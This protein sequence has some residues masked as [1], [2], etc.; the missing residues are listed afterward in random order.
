[1]KIDK[2]KTFRWMDI[3]YYIIFIPIFLLLIPTD[4]IVEKDPYFFTILMLYM[5]VIHFI[6]RKYNPV[7]YMIEGE[8]LK[9]SASAGATLAI[10]IILS[11]VEAL[12]LRH[13][14]ILSLNPERTAEM[15]IRSIWLLYFIEFTFITTT[16]LIMEIVRQTE[17]RARIEE[18]KNRAELSLYKSQINPHFM[19]N[20]LNTL[21]G[22]YITKSDKTGDMFLKFTDMIKYTFSTNDTNTVMLDKEVEYITEYIDLQSLRLGS[23]TTV[24]FECNIDDPSVMIPPMILITFVENAFKYG[25]SSSQKNEIKISISLTNRN[26]HFSTENTIFSRCE[27]SSTGIGIANCRKRLELLYPN[28]YTLFSGEEQG[29]NKYFTTLNIKL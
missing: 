18:Q 15:K 25:V 9:L 4:I 19:L 13:F 24:T 14:N 1:M 8:W 20:T 10:A 3:G 2:K 23:Q 28:R 12:D 11:R 21:Y 29:F 16:A 27:T 26:F 5:G 7:T 22:L 17:S 6:S